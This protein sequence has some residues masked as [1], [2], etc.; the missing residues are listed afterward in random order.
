MKSYD[1]PVIF[2]VKAI[3]K[4]EADSLAASICS[5]GCESALSY[6]RDT[7]ARIKWWN[8]ATIRSIKGGST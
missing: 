4:D 3:N 1:V 5:D 6:Q 2:R 8:F 7:K